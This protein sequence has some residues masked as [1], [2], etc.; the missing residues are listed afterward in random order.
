MYFDDFSIE[1]QTAKTVNTVV[2]R[3]KFLLYVNLYSQKEMNKYIIE[4]KVHDKS[5]IVSLF[6]YLLPY[7]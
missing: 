5:L 3:I 2:N 6:N 1:P 7:V 4:T